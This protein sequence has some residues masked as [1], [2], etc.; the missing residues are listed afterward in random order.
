M[1]MIC[2]KLIAWKSYIIKLIIVLPSSM[3][4]NKYA[5]SAPEPAEDGRTI[6]YFLP[7]S[8]DTRVNV[9]GEIGDM[10]YCKSFKAKVNLN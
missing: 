9:T 8:D 1:I 3:A 7:I 10:V 2:A 6:I 5:F 4:S